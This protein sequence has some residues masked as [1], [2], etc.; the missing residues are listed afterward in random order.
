MQKEWGILKKRFCGEFLY[1]EKSEMKIVA[2]NAMAE[3]STGKI[4]L[5]IASCA[6]KHG[7][8]V[9]TFSTNYSGKYYKKLPPAPE[10]HC[11]YSTFAENFVHLALG[12]IT[13][14]QECFGHFN[15]LRLIKK[16]DQIRPDIIHLHNMHSAYV[17]LGM[18]FGYIKKRHIRV[19]WTLHDCW[20]FTGQCPYFTLAKCNKW[21]MG[22]H[23]C[24][25]YKLYP[26][27]YVDRTKAMWKLKK[28]W[29]TMPDKMI[30][31]TPS[32]WLSELVK[33]SFL[34]KYPVEVINNGIDLDIFKP[35]I[36]DFRS[37]YHLKNKNIVLGVSFSWGY[38]KGLDVFVELSKRLGS[39]Y[40]IVLV[41]T[42]ETVDK[43]LPQ[44]I[45]SI[46][47]T[48]DPRELAAIYSAADVFVNPTREENYP[49]V[50]M[51]ALACG[52]PVVTYK[53][54]G[55]PEM[56]DT[57]CGIAVEID[58]LQGIESAIVY[59]CT[60]GSYTQ[61]ACVLR[62]KSFNMHEKFEKYI[63]LYERIYDD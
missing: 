23:D 8:E 55:S 24:T 15:T 28:K 6:R 45:I 53:T 10:G 36:S 30:V 7:M 5:Q 21:K 19:V 20:A 63:E 32:K 46:H 39:N 2:I 27:A 43:E 17:N 37:Q 62:A 3:G 12:M 42:N 25:Q 34:K 22:C 59:A 52:T 26:K 29:F 11:Y 16:I 49:T 44:N 33:Q 51:E 40:Q 41:G 60:V 13:G 38:R 14:Y 50:N 9:V 18:L 31:V 58:D 35:T 4:M 48:N 54:G 1:E 56:L 57:S 61:E 47:R